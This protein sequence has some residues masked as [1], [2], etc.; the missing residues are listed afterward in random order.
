LGVSGAHSQ[1]A[2]R[3]GAPLAQELRLIAVIDLLDGFDQEGQIDGEGTAAVLPE[4]AAPLWMAAG[5]RV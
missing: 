1:Q 5:I 3:E 2:S 4:R